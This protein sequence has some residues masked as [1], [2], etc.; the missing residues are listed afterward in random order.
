MS[1]ELKFGNLIFKSAVDN[2]E[3]IPKPVQDLL[4]EWKGATPVEEILSAE[5]DP[6]FSDSEKFCIKYE[7][8]P[9]DGA[10]CLVVRSK[11]GGE[12]KYAAVLVPV[13]KRADING[14]I[15]RFLGGSDASFASKE[16]AVEESGMEFGSITVVGLPEDWQ[17]LVDKSLI[18]IPYLIIGGGLRKSKL[19]I[20]GKALAELP[21]ATVLENLT[22][23]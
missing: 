8:A 14:V 9:N 20:P 18:D 15:R 1:V 16:F 7:I 11:R 12:V 3:I 2:P 19:L 10:N 5:I 17:I 23:A 13:D 22:K 21:N 4:K 6:E